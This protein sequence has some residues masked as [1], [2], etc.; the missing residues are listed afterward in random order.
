MSTL[1]QITTFMTVVEEHGFAAAAR[2]QG[3]STAAISRK[4]AALEDQ[5]Q[6]QLLERTTRKIA[7]TELGETYYKQCKK[8]LNALQEAE[9]AM[10]QSKQEAT[11]ILQVM[12]NRY[13]AM[14]HLIPKLPEFMQQNPQVKINFQLA[15]RFPNLETEGIDILFGVSVE[16]SE[17]LVRRRVATT[18]YVLCASPEYLKN[19]GA[20]TQP[21]DL[22]HHD[23]ITHSFRKPD[24]VI[25]F[26][27]GK[28]IHINPKLW[29][30]DSYA[31]RESAIQGM[32]I[33]NLHDYMVEDSLKD[34]TL[35]EILPNYQ[36]P[37][38]NIYLYYQQSRYLQPKIRRFIDFILG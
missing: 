32:G 28:E 2:K 3:V 4:I 13:F 20:P 37:Q 34:G 19:H 25:T 35:I 16:G 22:I 24:D 8:A 36:E 17:E 26:K 30:N 7:L 12:A 11:G 31:M 15:E 5:L 1:E 29:L 23:Y 6:T 10:A 14:T 33:V 38:K 9:N 18:R 27:N 21:T